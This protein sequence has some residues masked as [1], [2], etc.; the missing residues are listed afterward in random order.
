[1]P[2]EAT[3]PWEKVG[4]DLFTW[5]NKDYLLTIDYFSGWWEVDRLYNTTTT[6]V[7]R[8]LKSHFARWGIP[9][10]IVSDNGPQYTADKFREFTA[11]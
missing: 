1:M 10:A 9:S 4:T 11:E 6:A 5:D 8:A 3:R 2:I 7:I